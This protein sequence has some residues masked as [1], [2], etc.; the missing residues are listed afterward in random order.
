MR[1]W[2]KNRDNWS[3]TGEIILNSGRSVALPA[4]WFS[5]WI[6]D[7][8]RKR[9]QKLM[10][11]EFRE[12]LFVN[13]YHILEKPYVGRKLENNDLHKSLNFQ[14]P[15]MADSGGFLF[16]RLPK[17]NVDPLVI[18]NF[19]ERLQVDIGLVLD[20][21][22]D[23]KS[24][25]DEEKRILT[26]LKNT[27]AMFREKKSSELLLLPI[28]HASSIE[29]MRKM[30]QCL[31]R[32]VDPEGVCVGSVVPLIR[33]QIHDGRKLMVNLLIELRHLLPESFIHVL[34]IGGTT[35]MHLMFYL[36]VDSIDS[37]AWEKKAGYG[38]IQLPKI[39]DRFVIKRNGRERYPALSS[40]E[41]KV[42][43][44][45]KCPVCKEHPSQDLDKSRDLRVVHNA[46]VFQ[47][48]VKEARRSI[49]EGTYEEFVKERMKTSSMNSTFLYAQKLMKTKGMK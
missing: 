49:E 19:Q 28:V 20:H 15:I 39:G 13:I 5:I 16:R 48:E 18:L 42:L 7:E 37:C 1:I 24:P 38:L 14:G 34:G 3:R 36:G 4:L 33:T 29:K 32:K 31:K 12:A 22:L 6:E 47:N 44:Q 45:C 2:I 9:Y 23:Y 43:L 46:W 26:T 35:T 21:P 40:K 10:K 27:K 17:I 11:N 8:L 41:C 30:I 25:Q